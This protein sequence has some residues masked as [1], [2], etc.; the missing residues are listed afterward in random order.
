MIIMIDFYIGTDNEISATAKPIVAIDDKATG[1]NIKITFNENINLGAQPA[2]DFVVKDND[3]KT[4]AV[5][6]VSVTGKELT[7]TLGKAVLSATLSVKD[8]R[9]ITDTAKVAN[10]IA[11]IDAEDS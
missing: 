3:G 8:A 10:A 7:I 1:T 6:E 2:T 4:V 11:D 5:K 9:F